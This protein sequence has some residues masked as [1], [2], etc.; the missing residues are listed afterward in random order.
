MSNRQKISLVAHEIGPNWM[1]ARSIAAILVKHYDVELITAVK[2]GQE[3]ETDCFSDL[4]VELHNVVAE[5]YPGFLST[6]KKMR[7]AISGDIIYAMKLRPGSFGISLLEGLGQHGHPVL[8]DVDDWEKFMCYPYS[9]YWLKNMVTSLP[10][11][12]DPNSFIHT[13]LVEYLNRFSDGTTSVSNFFQQRYGGV[14]L[15]NGCDTE[16][17]NP[18]HFDRE[19]LRHEKGLTPQDKVIMFVGTAEPNKGVGQIV[20]AIKYLGRPELKLVIVGRW[21]DYLTQL[22]PNNKVLY[23]GKHSPTLSPQFLSIA[24]LVILPQLSLPHSVGQMP[25]KLFEAM[26]MEIPV[27]STA[28]AD[29]AEVLAEDSG[30]IADSAGVQDLASKILWILDH[31]E[32]SRAM[33]RLARQRC[34]QLYSWHNMER[35]LLEKVLAPY[36]NVI[37]PHTATTMQ[38]LESLEH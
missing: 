36:T 11:L 34:E 30:L 13:W 20:E 32:E 17:F 33:G 9:K 1:R 10:R 16:L 12:R 7:R 37:T 23:W 8:L 24:D 2:P 28:V 21:T 14:L 4:P 26:A 18:A 35:I 6:I 3:N 25:M 31:P 29:I 27:I 22:V 15:P 38:Q 5:P 19:R